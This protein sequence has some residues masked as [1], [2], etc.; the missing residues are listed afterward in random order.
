MFSSTI[1]CNFTNSIALAYSYFIND[2]NDY[3]T[4]VQ[5]ND[6]YLYHLNQVNVFLVFNSHAVHCYFYSSFYSTFKHR[7]NSHIISL[8]NRQPLFCVHLK[9]DMRMHTNFKL[10][11]HKSCVE[12]EVERKSISKYNNTYVCKVKDAVFENY[13]Q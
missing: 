10:N 5:S 2:D 9:L 7:L 3:S 13:H 4:I 12:G 8:A 11:V 6:N 1:L